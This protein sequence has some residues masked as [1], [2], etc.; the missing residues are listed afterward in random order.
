MVQPFHGAYFMRIVIAAALL[1][2]ASPL[3]A[4]TAP[5]TAGA[6]VPVEHYLAAHATGDG[7]HN[8]L[9]FAPQA[10][11]YWVAADTLS[12]RTSEAY[13]AGSRGTPAPDEAQRKRWIESIDVA[14]TAGVAKVILDY[15][16]ARFVD[17]L[18]LLKINGEW[19]IINKIFY[20]EQKKR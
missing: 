13:I 17:Y 4:Q 19:K 6:R 15:P 12:T 7:A 16:T 8:R 11:L 18:S 14:G 3:A 10:S 1:A 2:C 20:V 9:A 5:D